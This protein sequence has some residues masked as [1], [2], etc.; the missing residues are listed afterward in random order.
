MI[1]STIKDHFFAG[2]SCFKRSKAI[3]KVIADLAPFLFFTK[4]NIK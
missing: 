4:L 3:S 1:K 2:E